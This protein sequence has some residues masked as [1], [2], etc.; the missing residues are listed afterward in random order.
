MLIA[1]IISSSML[2]IG[3]DYYLFYMEEGS[4]TTDFVMNHH[5]P[6]ACGVTTVSQTL[7][8]R[9]ASLSVLAEN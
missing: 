5:Q 1:T 3:E 2:E 8:A 4:F 7:N 6:R 9:M